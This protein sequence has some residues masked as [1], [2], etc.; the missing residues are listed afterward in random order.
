MALL[1]KPPSLPIETGDKVQHMMAF[2]TLS[3]LAAAGWRERRLAVL[4]AWLAGFGAAIEVLQ[5]IPVLNRDSD[6]LDW[7]ADMAATIA[8]LGLTRA[9]L[10][11]SARR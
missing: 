7:V 2:A 10:G 5:A 9:L 3:A 6:V 4:F 8:A 11:Y 1:P